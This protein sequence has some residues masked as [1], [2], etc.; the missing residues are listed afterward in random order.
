MSGIYQGADAAGNQAHSGFMVL[1]LFRNTNDHRTVV[2][3]TAGGAVREGNRLLLV[4]D[5]FGGDG[6]GV[7][8]ELALG[9]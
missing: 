6:G 3:R 8:N 4:F 9:A 1:Y 2:A 7:G 5:G